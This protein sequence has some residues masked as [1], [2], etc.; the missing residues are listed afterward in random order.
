MALI[1]FDAIATNPIIADTIRVTGAE[2]R[3]AAHALL[4]TIL[5]IMSKIYHVEGGSLR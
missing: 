5:D 2:Y 4:P 3:H 1:P